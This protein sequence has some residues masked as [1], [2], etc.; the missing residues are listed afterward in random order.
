MSNTYDVDSPPFYTHPSYIGCANEL[1]P[2]D[3]R[4]DKY[5]AQYSQYG[6][7]DTCTWNLDLSIVKFILPRLKRFREVSNGYPARLNS[8]AE[9]HEVLDKIIKSFTIMDKQ[10]QYLVAEEESDKEVKEGL[11][12]FVEYLSDLWW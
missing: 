7:D 9:Y 8:M 10:N 4:L 6:F 2:S 5:D 11:H 1:L 12:L 3:E